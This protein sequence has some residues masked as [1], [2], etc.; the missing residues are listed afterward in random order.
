MQQTPDV[1]RNDVLRVTAREFPNDVDV[2]LA[3]FDKLSCSLIEINRLH[4]SHLKLSGGSLQKLRES[5][6][7][8][9]PRDV[10]SRAEYPDY[11]KRGWAVIDKLSQKEVQAIIDDDW[12]Q[13]QSWLNAE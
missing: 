12:R 3:I 5:L 9:D 4:L 1:T 10:V 13:Y 2:V 7:I 11:S 6:T 8:S